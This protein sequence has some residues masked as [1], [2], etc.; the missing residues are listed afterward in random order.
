MNVARYD[1][2]R[3]SYTATSLLLSPEWLRYSEVR[4]YHP[5]PHMPRSKGMHTK[6][7][8]HCSKM[9]R[10]LYRTSFNIK[11]MVRSNAGPQY[12][13]VQGNAQTKPGSRSHSLL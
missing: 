9:N 13:Q 1:L 6:T 11:S 8:H 4:C 12:C 5:L 3:A 7:S 2:R 10:V